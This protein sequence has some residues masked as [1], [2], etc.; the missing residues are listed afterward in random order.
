MNRVLFAAAAI[1]LVASLETLLLAKSKELY[2]AFKAVHSGSTAG[3]YIGI[4]FINFLMNI[5]EPILISLYLF[6]SRRKHA[7]SPLTKF[8]FSGLIVIRMVA[9]VAVWNVKSIFYYAIIVLYLLFLGAI[10][11]LP[12][13]R[14]GNR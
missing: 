7:V 3:E 5:L 10:V 6:L 12:A 2:M 14:K 9:L 11:A 4:V 13:T 1:I 8:I